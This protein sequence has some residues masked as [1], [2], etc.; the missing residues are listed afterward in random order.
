VDRR[1]LAPALAHLSPVPGRLE[2]IPNPHGILAFVDYA[3]TDDALTN[4]LTTL[5]EVRKRRLIV[6][7][8]C[9]G[10]RDRSKRPLMGAVATALA[11]QVIVTSDNPR[12]EDPSA[13]IAEIMAGVGHASHVQAVVDREQAIAR[14]AALAQPGDLLLVAGKGHENYQEIGKTVAPFDDREVLHRYLR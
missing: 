2:R 7:F 12:S 11:D 3:H 8:G 4:V 1:F 14:A 10:D 13:I 9:G 5:R 6:V